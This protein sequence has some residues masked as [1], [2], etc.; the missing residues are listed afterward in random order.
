MEKRSFPRRKLDLA[1]DLIVNG[2]A[3]PAIMTDYSLSGMAILIKGKSDLKAEVLDLKIEDLHLNTTGKIIW[4]REMS[5]GLKVGAI[6]M[7]PLEGILDCYELSDLLLGIQRAR[8]TGILHLETGQSIRKIYFKDGEMVFSSSNQEQEQ[9]SAMLL[10]AD[11]ISSRQYENTLSLAEETGKSQGAVLVEMRYITPQE[12]IEAVHKKVESVVMNICSVVNA[13]FNFREEALPRGEIVM[14]KLN[15]NDLL[16]RGFRRAERIDAF[17]NRYLDHHTRVSASPAMRSILDRLV[18]DAQDRE[19]LSLIN[20]KTS[21]KEILLMSPLKEE[22]TLRS[23]YALFNVHLLEMATERVEEEKPQEQEAAPVGEAVDPVIADKIDSLYRKHK[24]LGYQ[25]VLGLLPNASSLDIKRAYHAMAKE[26][27]PDRYLLMKSEEL[28]L[29]LNVIF[30][31]INEAYRELS[32]PGSIRQEQPQPSASQQASSGTNSETM[33]QEKY[34]QGRES[35]RDKDY[36]TAMTLFGQA[37]YLNESVPDYHY[38]YGI[39]LLRNKKI[40]ESEAS[41]RKALHLSPY[42]ADY[43]AELGHIYLKLGFMTRA[44]NAFDKALRIDPSQAVAAEGMKTI[45]ALQED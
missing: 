4:K 6:R 36:E 2:E 15:S 32:R 21:L 45:L 25:G 34:L 41:M 38:Y 22:D 26:Y 5:A 9:L 19:I 40:R 37:V 20:G 27:H 18:L 14:L 17:R 13:K 30:A 29:K 39:T 43:V 8:K 31:Y 23:V 35:F 3:V 10:A 44:R 24:T 1:F 11:K 16:Y 7:G 12:L 28:R 42:N 33:A